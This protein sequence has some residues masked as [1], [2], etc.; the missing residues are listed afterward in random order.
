MKKVFLIGLVVLFALTGTGFAKDEFH[1]PPGKWWLLPQVAERLN[2]TPQEQNKLD[3]LYVEGTTR[4][5]DL[6]S[7]VQKE[8]FA[9]E[10]LFDNAGFDPKACMAQHEK[11]QQ[12][13]MNLS[14]ERFR[15]LVEVRGLLGLER[16][17]E[18][19]MMRREFMRDKWEKHGRRQG[20]GRGPGAVPGHGSGP[21]MQ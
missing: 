18:L 19:K 1:L 6:K 4:M 9:L 11:L 5:I 17:Q 14:N 2:L 16:F 3:E 7:Q 15:V 12:A 21:A 20:K 10:N 13:R 8:R